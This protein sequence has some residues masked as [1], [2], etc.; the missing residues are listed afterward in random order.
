M[1]KNLL[2][3]IILSLLIVNIALTAIMMF[4]VMKTNSATGAIVT[5]IASIVKVELDKDGDKGG[6]GTVSLADT[7]VYSIPDQLTISLKPDE[8]ETKTRYC[9]VSVSLSMNKK[10]DDYSKN[11]DLSTN[12]PLI[13]S[14]INSVIGSYTYSEAQVSQDQILD[15][16][17]QRIQ[18][19]Y[20]SDFIY[21]VSFSSFMFG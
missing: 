21:K 2:S 14:E 13:K 20:G 3:L 10:H 9:I 8:G 16:I 4:S 18:N 1:K 17:L 7:E 19:L 6:D 11:K 12:E 15:E 5:D